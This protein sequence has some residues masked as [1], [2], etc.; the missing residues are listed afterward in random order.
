MLETM[1]RLWSKG[2]IV[3]IGPPR[4]VA[5]CYECKI[6]KPGTM[7]DSVQVAYGDTPALAFSSAVSAMR[8]DA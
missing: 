7:T 2:Y 5:A 6:T 8:D 3:S 1:E 4:N